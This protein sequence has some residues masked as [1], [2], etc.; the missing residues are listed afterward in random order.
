MR[1]AA[2]A[3][4]PAHQDNRVGDRGETVAGYRQRQGAIAAP[5]AGD[6]TQ[7]IHPELLRPRLL[8]H[9]IGR[10]NYTISLPSPP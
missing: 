2:I 4:S 10:P 5:L 8:V 1:Q 6:Q 7:T 9:A 3:A